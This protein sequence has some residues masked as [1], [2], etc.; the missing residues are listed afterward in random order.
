MTCKQ[1]SAFLADYLDGALPWRQRLSFNIHLVLCQ[2]C[3]QYLASYAATIRVAKMIG[4]A[5]EQEIPDE[6]VR[7]VLRARR[8]SPDGEIG[9]RPPAPGG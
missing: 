5:P 9:D 6:L 4:Q 2:H 8:N 3:Q 7:A 1:V